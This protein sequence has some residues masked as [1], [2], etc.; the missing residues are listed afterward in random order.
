MRTKHFGW[1]VGGV[2]VLVLLLTG[3]VP[4]AQAP[5]GPGD[6]VV[7]EWGTFTTVAN[8]DGAATEWLPLG[9]QGDLP[10]FVEFYKN[11]LFKVLTTQYGAALTYEQARARLRGKV[12]METPVLYFHADRE[13][14]VDVS[15]TFPQGLFTEWYPR[16]EVLQ[17]AAHEH[18]LRLAPT[19]NS[20]I[21]WKAVRV[22]PDAAPAFPTDGKPSHYY[23]ARRTDASPVQV[24]TQQE[25]FLFYR[26]VGGFPVPV[27]AILGEEDTVVIR[28]LGDR[29]L[30]GVVLFHRQGDS[31]SYRVQGTLDKETTLNLP[32]TA[33]TLDGILAYLEG[34]L[35]AQ[36]LY[37][38]EARAMIDTW[39]DTWFEDGMRVFYVLPSATVDGI[40]PLNVR[41]EPT[42]VTRVFVGRMDVITPAM[43]AAVDRALADGDTAALDRYGR[44]IGPI[45]DRLLASAPTAEA[46][47]RISDMLDRRL[48]AFVARAGGC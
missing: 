39:R 41:P 38:D 28:N 13:T 8:A 22:V 37:Q 40:L 18:L 12:R 11:R 35:V 21:D 20:T 36:G 23:A 31:V 16:A 2:A 34:T 44:L 9:G 4:G 7:H 25:K 6:L 29:P 19:L 32:A 42:A 14:T 26:G 47:R 24:G 5:S 30:P 10:C 3:A 33:G 27:S 17:P 1:A 46:K 43:T 15:V 45:G 48:A